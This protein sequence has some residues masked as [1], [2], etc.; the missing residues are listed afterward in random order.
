[1]TAGELCASHIGT[2]VGVGERYGQLLTVIHDDTG[3]HALIE[4]VGWLDRL[5][6]DTPITPSRIDD[7]TR[8]LVAT[9]PAQDDLFG[10]TP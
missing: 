10:G 6:A 1:M 2:Y 3:T 4:R 5:P 7:A 8:S 9:E